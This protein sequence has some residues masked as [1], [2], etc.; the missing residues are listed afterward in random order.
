MSTHS[1]RMTTFCLVCLPPCARSRCREAS[2]NMCRFCFFTRSDPLWNVAALEREH[3]AVFLVAYVAKRLVVMPA[4]VALVLAA[5][6]MGPLGCAQDHTEIKLRLKDGHLFTP[7]Q[8]G[9]I[10]DYFNGL[11]QVR[12]PQNT[13]RLLAGTLSSW[14]ATAC[15]SMH[16]LE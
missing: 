16:C 14:F 12:H 15:Q 1:D 8:C 6:T 10:L 7:K 4:S 2:A 5:G 11:E 3:L 13:T 9:Y